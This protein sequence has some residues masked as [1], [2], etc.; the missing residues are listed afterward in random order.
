MHV[1]I[2]NISERE[3]QQGSKCKIQGNI[4]RTQQKP[5]FVEYFILCRVYKDFGNQQI[6]T[7]VTSIRVSRMLPSS[8]QTE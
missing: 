6:V 4:I 7:L 5:L 1:S 2:Q 3:A 8:D